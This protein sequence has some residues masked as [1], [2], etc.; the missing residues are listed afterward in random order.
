M[1]SIYESTVEVLRGAWGWVSGAAAEVNSSIGGDVIGD[2]GS[3]VNE[4][5]NP[6]TFPNDNTLTQNKYDFTRRVFPSDLE[7]ADSYNGHYMVININAQN[8]S[9]LSSV[10]T[11]GTAVPLFNTLDQELSKTDALRFN[12]DNNFKNDDGVTLGQ[13]WTSRP[14]FTRRIVESIALYM[15]NGELTYSDRH[16]FDDISMSKIAGNIVGKFAGAALGGIVGG[17]T[18]V[19]GGPLAGAAAGAVAGSVVDSVGKNLGNISQVVGVPINPKVE[20]LFTNTAQREFSFEF[21]M[22]PANEKESIAVEQIIR[23]IRFH[24]APELKP[25]AI[26]SFFYVP[27]SEFDIT[28]FYRGKENTNIPRINTAVLTGIDVSYSPIGVYST[29]HNGHPVAVRMMLHFRETEITHKLRV[30]QGF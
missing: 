4:Q 9:D 23:T 21:L 1:S 27:P 13:T 8:N 11:G 26:S 15:P 10:T 16:Q 24:A 25:G 28:F 18:S 29:F 7:N 14:R 5:F 17:I 30:A 2:I 19:V 22:A 3:N 6:L 12:I 20:V